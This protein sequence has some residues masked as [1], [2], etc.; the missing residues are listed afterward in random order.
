MSQLLL[1]TYNN[2][3]RKA[4]KTFA[5][6]WLV[7]AYFLNIKMHTCWAKR[8][9]IFLFSNYFWNPLEKFKRL[10]HNHVSVNLCKRILRLY[11]YVSILTSFYRCRCISSSN[12]QNRYQNWYL[13]II[14]KFQL[15]YIFY[16]LPFRRKF[17]QEIDV[18]NL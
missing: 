14:N 6:K 1:G 7:F 4:W 9:F 10:V 3:C 16:I 18:H 12:K 8:L 11:M 2:D 13:F 15:L 17:S 5:Q